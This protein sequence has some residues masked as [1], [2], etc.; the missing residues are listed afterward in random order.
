VHEVAWAEGLKKN[1][2]YFRAF[3]KAHKPA[4]LGALENRGRETASEILNH[5]AA[6]RL[7]DGY[8]FEEAVRISRDQSCCPFG[9]KESWPNARSRARS[10]VRE[11]QRDFSRCYAHCVNLAIKGNLHAVSRLI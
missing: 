1:I 10:I 4:S 9:S 5:L 11:K 3:W 2:E 6:L 8:G 7:Y